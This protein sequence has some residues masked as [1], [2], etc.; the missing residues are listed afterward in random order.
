MKLNQFYELL[1]KAKVKYFVIGIPLYSSEVPEGDIDIIVDK[2]DYHKLQK[3]IEKFSCNSDM[4]LLR[5][6]SAGI[7]LNCEHKYFLISRT[8]PNIVYQLDIWVSL[9][10]RG[11]PFLQFSNF[12]KCSVLNNGIYVLPD[13]LSNLVGAIKDILYL[14]KVKETRKTILMQNAIDIRKEIPQCCDRKIV[15]GIFKNVMSDGVVD[16]NLKWKVRLRIFFNVIITQPFHQIG[17]WLVYFQNIFKIIFSSNDRTITM[18]FYG[19]DGVG[20]STLIKELERT[21]GIEDL[22]CVRK[23]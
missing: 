6:K 23:I 17:A 19:P 5:R 15:E 8:N 10:W 1:N 16:A 20:K 2:K 4:Y 3:V 21:K 11:I 12:K 13:E 9:H 7:Q 18:A 22:F 14:G